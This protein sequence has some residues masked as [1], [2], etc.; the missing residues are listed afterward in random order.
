MTSSVLY[1]F[2]NLA[3]PTQNL[4]YVRVIEISFPLRIRLKAYLIWSVLVKLDKN[5][6]SNIF[7]KTILFLKKIKCFNF[8]C[9][10]LRTQYYNTFCCSGLVTLY[11]AVC[12]CGELECTCTD[13]L[14]LTPLGSFVCFRILSKTK[15]NKKPRYL[16]ICCCQ[17]NKRIFEL[18]VGPSPGS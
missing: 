3:K 15:Q 12:V 1:N 11:Y 10:L 7:C 2:K 18:A 17:L 5:K 4:I 6:N 8:D 16:D 14:H 9:N 13:M